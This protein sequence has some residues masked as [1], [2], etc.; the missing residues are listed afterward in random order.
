MEQ[1][2]EGNETLRIR[3][4]SH[5]GK[6]L[7]ISAD[8]LVSVSEQTPAYYREF[9]KVIKG[10]VRHLL[11]ALEP[12]ASLQRKILDRILCRL[13][14]SDHAFGVIK[15]RGIRD[16]AIEH[17]RARYVAKLDIKDFYPS[18]RHQ[19][20]YNFFIGQEC[21]PDVSK[22]LTQL[23]TWQYALP[24]GAATSPF[25]ADQIV[26]SVDGRIAGIA[27]K[28]GLKYTRYVDDITISGEFELERI[29]ALIIRIISQA[30]FRIKRS[31]LEI[32]RPSDTKERIVTGVRIDGGRLSAPRAYVDEL[33]DDLVEA[34][35]QSLRGA[36][37]GQFMTRQHYL[38]R[39]GYVLWLDRTIGKDLLRIYRKVN[40][41]HLEWS[42]ACPGRSSKAPT[43]IPKGNASAS[44]QQR[45]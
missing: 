44:E 19:K 39:I 15:G 1:P 43:A 4:I 13:S 2:G 37:A 9:D 6:Q 23:T 35:Q 11:M 25:L 27:R 17:R 8:H 38:G 45:G 22:I 5:L 18:I 42:G 26:C 12:L 21:S 34:L 28:H 33:R 14:A 3:R 31:K 10:K 29:A 41:R 16:N 40:W 24:L 20:V 32:Y 36:P 30:G 7:G